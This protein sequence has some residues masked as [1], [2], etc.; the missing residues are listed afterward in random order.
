MLPPQ[1]VYAVWGWS[2]WE[3]GGNIFQYEDFCLFCENVDNLLDAK[4]A[5]FASFQWVP[6]YV[7][8][9]AVC[10]ASLLCNFHNFPFCLGL[11]RLGA[12]LGFLK[13]FLDAYISIRV[14]MSVSPSPSVGL[15]VCPSISRSETKYFTKHHCKWCPTASKGTSIPWPPPPPPS[16]STNSITRGRIFFL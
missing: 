8:F 14:C 9:F 5:A 12:H 2:D 15:W 11:I 10:L 4:V 7:A 6:I 3:G 16:F 13:Q 1:S